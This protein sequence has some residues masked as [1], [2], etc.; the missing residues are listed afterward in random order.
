[1]PTYRNDS[2]EIIFGLKDVNE[3]TITLKPNEIL[4]TYKIYDIDDLT[5]TSDEPYFSLTKVI[6][7]AFSSPGTK[8]GLLGCSVIRL[9]AK[10]SGITIKCNLAANPNE[11][12][13][14]Y[15]TPIDIKNNGEIESLVFIG[16]GEVQIEGF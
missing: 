10:T 7:L 4:E 16:S 9:T 8:T 6:D 11:F 2:D 14:P 15:N 1:M 5:K 12:S 3:R 13:L